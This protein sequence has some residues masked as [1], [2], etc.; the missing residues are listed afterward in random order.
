[1]SSKVS[2]RNKDTHYCI[3]KQKHLH[4]TKTSRP[5]DKVLQYPTAFVQ[6][7]V[8][9]MNAMQKMVGRWTLY[10]SA[11]CL[12]T[13]VLG[14]LLIRVS[15]CGF[16]FDTRVKGKTWL[17]WFQIMI[18]FSLQVLGYMIKRFSKI[19]HIGDASKGSLSSY[20]YTLLVIYFLQR[21]DPPVLPVLQEVS[22][23]LYF[24]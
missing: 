10:F 24:S 8:K 4:D 5:T 15:F 9:V 12:F 23:I 3:Y 6:L 16:G 22:L 18:R 13:A 2:I 7:Q 11:P 17:N 21:C 19:C 20:A 14:Y 1:M